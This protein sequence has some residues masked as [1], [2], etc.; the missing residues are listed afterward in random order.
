MW[1]IIFVL[2]LLIGLLSSLEWAIKPYTQYRLSNK[3]PDE[4]MEAWVNK[5]T[6]RRVLYVLVTTAAF[7]VGF[8]LVRQELNSSPVLVQEEPSVVEESSTEPVK[9]P[10]KVTPI[11][12][13]VEPASTYQ[14]YRSNQKPQ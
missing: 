3:S 7:A 13:Q 5:K 8:S 9:I 12:T 4:V 11:K 6:Q 14:Q 10:S 1:D 2:I